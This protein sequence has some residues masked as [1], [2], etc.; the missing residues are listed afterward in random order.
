MKIG[1]VGLGVVGTACMKGL[2]S[3]GNKVIPHDIL[4]DTEI[5]DLI[6]CEIIYLCVPT[7]A[8][9]DGSCNTSIVESV[10]CSLQELSY[11][12][13]IAIK[14]TIDV[15][16]TQAFQ[17]KFNN[18][19]ICFVPEFLKERSALEDFLNHGAL[20]IG[21]SDKDIGE[22][23]QKSHGKLPSKTIL[24]SETEAEIVKYFHNTF[25]ALR[26]IFA[27]SFYEI[28]QFKESS[29]DAVLEAIIERNDYNDSYLRV[30]ESL[31][32]Y[33]GVCLPKD[34]LAISNFCKVNKLNISLFETIHKENQKYKKTIFKNMR[35]GDV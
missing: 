13:I 6:D 3:Q 26:I 4:L 11:E 34:T 25:N 33:A 5:G 8:N 17:K 35:I 21:S 29:Y 27:N 16:S 7:P 24:I 23:I 1:I 12:G 18:N 28:C 32:G 30:D 31:R 2:E 15:G 19:K 20:V 22:I 9:A 14:S 10:I